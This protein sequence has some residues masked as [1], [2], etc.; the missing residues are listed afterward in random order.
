VRTRFFENLVVR[1][2]ADEEGVISE[3]EEA[4]IDV[5]LIDS[6]DV[7]EFAYESDLRNFLVKNLCKIEAGLKLYE[8]PDGTKGEE[9]YIPGTARRID[10]LAT[11]KDNNFVVIELKVSRGYERV[12]GQTLYYQSKIK[13]HYNHQKVRAIIIAREISAELK[14]ATQFLQDFE[15]FEYELSLTL[16]KVK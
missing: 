3:D 11:D 7:K 12:V 14:A 16:S 10:I 8:G 1:F 5:D 6:V 2:N 9:F 13:T 15:L 4:E